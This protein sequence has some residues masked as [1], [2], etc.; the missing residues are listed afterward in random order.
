MWH[1]AFASRVAKVGVP[2][3]LCCSY[4]ATLC[5]G[6]EMGG[7]HRPYTQGIFWATV[8]SA[9]CRFQDMR[10]VLA[11]GKMCDTEGGKR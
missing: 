2:R 9:F 11:A 3:E 8:V 7:R 4:L 1:S 5:R 6:A 10:W